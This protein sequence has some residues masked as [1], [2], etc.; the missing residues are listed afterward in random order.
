MPRTNNLTFLGSKR[1]KLKKMSISLLT[2]VCLN[3]TV[4]KDDKKTATLVLSTLKANSA[5]VRETLLDS[6]KV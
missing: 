6:S 5:W 3:S 4:Q 1:L 2:I